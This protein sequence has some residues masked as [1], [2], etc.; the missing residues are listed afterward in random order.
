MIKY[1]IGI[2]SLMLVISCGSSKTF[3]DDDRLAYAELQALVASQRFEINS[4]VARPMAT[5][6]FSQ[7]ANSGILQPGSNIA[8]IDISGN[9]NS[10]K[11]KGDS[12]I[13]YFP[14]FGEQRFGAGYPGNR[15]QGIEFRD[16]PETYEVTTNDKKQSVNIKINI[17][18][19]HRNGENY[20]LFITLFPNNRSVISINSTT[21]TVIEYSGKVKPLKDEVEDQ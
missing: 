1:I 7:L 16:L 9:P 13:G 6:A 8:N 20:N 15:H 2:S 4:D 3:S 5:A 11:V 10:L 12:I 21:R 14:Y 19:L 18:D 17:D